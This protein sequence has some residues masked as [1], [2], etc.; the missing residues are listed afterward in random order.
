MAE[1]LT[2]DAVKA[3]FESRGF[4][5]LETE[6]VNSETPMLYRCACG[7]V[8]RMSYKN[9]KKGRSCADCGREKLARSK[10]VYDFTY[11]SDYFEKSGC[12]LLETAYNAN[13]H[14]RMRY[15]CVCGSESVT[16]W[17]RF[18]NGHRCKQCR[19]AKVADSRRKYT[20]GEVAE[21]FKARGKELLETR[22]FSNSAKPLSYRCFCGT[23]SRISL[24][25]FL[26]GEDCG[27]CRKRKISSALRNPLITDD[28]RQIK[29]Q[30]PGYKEWRTAVYERDQYTCQ[31]CRK[32]G[33]RLNA[34]HILNYATHKELR[35]VLS[36]GVTLCKSCHDAFHT[37][38]GKQEN[39]A[40]QILEFIE[41]RRTV[42]V[43]A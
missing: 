26:K 5:L 15:I 6:Y 17:S 14:E 1:K 19:T 41:A 23:V 7:N 40:E 32:V 42:E 33:A 2:F 39:T 30:F 27:E 37:V 4:Q 24:N 11:I 29:R 36:N 8:A 28:E 13:P 9:A 10:Q 22:P 12:R 43:V 34:H 16:T 38:Y 21:M 35:T 25:N 18:L 20:I 31:C 3:V